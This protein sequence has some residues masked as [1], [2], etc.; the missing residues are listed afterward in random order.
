MG[1]I[2]DLATMFAER[3]LGFRADETMKGTH[4]FVQDYA[5]GKVRAGTEL[6]FS[7]SATWGHPHLEQFINPLSGD[8]MFTLLEGT[9]TAGGLT[10]EAPIKGT[11]EFRYLRDATIR[12]TF[13]FEAQQRTF[14][15]VGEKRGIRPWNLHRTHTRCHGTLTDLTTDQPISRSVVTFDLWQLPWLMGSFRLG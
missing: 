5:P 13:E 11:L 8:F 2:K 6:P 9:V 14:R 7:F 15:Y 3:R 12:Y 4:M 10:G 1:R